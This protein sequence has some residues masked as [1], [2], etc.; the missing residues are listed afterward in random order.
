MKAAEVFRIGYPLVV[1]CRL[2][3]QEE[4]DALAHFGDEYR[5]HQET[6][7]MFCPRLRT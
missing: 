1:Y 7:S 6:S 3:K 2:A 4:A 5:R